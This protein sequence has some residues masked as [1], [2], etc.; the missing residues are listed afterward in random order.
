MLRFGKTKVA[1][2]E[3]YGAKKLINIWDVNVDNVVILSRMSFVP[4]STVMVEMFLI[5]HVTS[6]ERMFKRLCNLWVKASHGESST[7]HV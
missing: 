4:V 1:K 3:L 6:S 2:E 7:Y 5:C